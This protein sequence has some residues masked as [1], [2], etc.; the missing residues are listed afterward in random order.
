MKKIVQKFQYF[1]ISLFIFLITLLG[2]QSFLKRKTERISVNKF[3]NTLHQKQGKI[4]NY[5]NHIK[6]NFHFDN[7]NDLWKNIE[8]NFG[9]DFKNLSKEGFSFFI[10]KSDTL[11]YWTNNNVPIPIYYNYF[12]P[13]T[14]LVKLKNG[15]YYS[16]IDSLKDIKIVG[17]F[18]I[19]EE[20]FHENKSLTNN[21]HQDFNLSKNIAIS[22]F[23]ERNAIPIYDKNKNYVF[24]LHPSKKRIYNP[25][26]PYLYSFLYFIAVLLLIIPLKKLFNYL[27]NYYLKSKTYK[28]I[29]FAIALFLMR[30]IMVFYKIPAI[31]YFLELF[32]PQ[33]F[34]LTFG[35]NSLGNFLL[36]LIFISIFIYEIFKNYP[37]FVKKKILSRK[38]YFV[39]ISIIIS[40]FFFIFLNFLFVHYILKSFI[41]KASISLELF[42]IFTW[43]IST[44]AALLLIFLLL[45][46]L[47]FLIDRFIFF[48]K[49]EINF[50][51]LT[52]ISISVNL[53]SF[54]IC[55][56]FSYPIIYYSILFLIVLTTII[57]FL[58]YKNYQYSYT[59]NVLLILV[60]SIFTAI[61]I[62]EK[63]ETQ[64]KN[65]MLVLASNRN[66][67][68]DL[69]AEYLLKDISKEIKKDGLIAYFLQYQTDKIDSVLHYLEKKYFNSYWQKYNLEITICNPVDTLLFNTNEPPEHCYTFYQNLKDQQGVALENSNFSYLENTNGRISYFGSFEYTDFYKASKISLFIILDS[70][71]MNEELG[72]PE[73]LLSNRTFKKSGLKEYSFAKYKNGH[74]IHQQGKFPYSL[75]RSFYQNENVPYGF[76]NEDNFNHLVYNFDKNHTIIVSKPE[77]NYLDVLISFSY[78]F[79]FFNFLVIVFFFIKR[80]YIKQL[81]PFVFDFKTKMQFSMISLLLFSS[82]LI[83]GGTIFYNIK[84]YEKKQ[85]QNIKEKIQSILIELEHELIYLDKIPADWYSVSYEDLTDL[86]RKLTSVFY[87]DIHLYDLKGTLL[88]SSRP[89]IFNKGLIGTKINPLVYKEIVKRRRTQFIHNEHIGNLDYISAYVPLINNKGKALAYVCLPYFT[90]QNILTEEI[91]TL[92]VAGIN[93]CVL[94]ILLSSVVGIFIANK[95]TQPLR[96][97][98]EKFKN[99]E[100][101]K[102]YE[103]IYYEGKD[104]I[105]SLVSEYNRMVIELEKSIELLAQSERE[106][107]W[108]EM[109]KQ[110]AHEIKNPLTPIKLHI[111]MLLRSWENQDENFEKR[112]K[113]TSINIIEQINALSKIATEF[114][115]F[116]KMPKA[117]NVEFNLIKVLDDTIRLFENDETEVKANYIL[118]EIEIFADKEQVTRVF[119]NLVKNAIQAI[120]KN[121]IGLINVDLEKTKKYAIV[122]IEDNGSG[123]SAEVQEKLFQP[124]FT[125]K[126]SG[127]GMGLA[128]VKNIVEN[129]NGKIWFETSF[130]KGTTFFVK[131]PCL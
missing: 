82:V 101:G 100:L 18:L 110:I 6:N 130:N 26:Q 120:P 127:M 11:K 117:N 33:Y 78:I 60:L 21:F 102:D 123:I 66:T 23:K 38:N 35:F 77:L 34:G 95:I 88:A 93:L 2:E 25:F 105:G 91:S 89:E 96:L 48:V 73:L 57:S 116:A 52:I 62:T 84:Q 40:G 27:G 56:L 111:Q 61:F 112:L 109:A 22:F 47:C 108:R 86:L 113:K 124:N 103:Q 15:W 31:F 97:I 4:E 55:Y 70:K 49:S 14:E 3:S 39:K 85:V 59:I 72:Y 68:R 80:L 64:E 104:E 12:Q 126:S 5:I 1:F 128:I 8:N 45:F 17:F 58:K 16:K 36:N 37:V 51:E 19:K 106:S 87:S 115:N 83:S 90:K 118:N 32:E 69:I 7:Q 125:T 74:L 29:A 79:V 75:D 71:L 121:K 42:K 63:I 65:K 24:S 81:N 10:Y 43:S 98:Q 114:S 50:K 131:F 46:T 129:A 54:L 122:S 94:L 9:S 30:F 119:I 44:G 20:Y 107:A 41:E 53:I 76:L 67:E 13:N 28:Y 92:I 99:I